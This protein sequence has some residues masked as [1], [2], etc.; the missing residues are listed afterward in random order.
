M[1][2]MELDVAQQ[3]STVGAAKLELLT[4]VMT[5]ARCIMSYDLF[6]DKSGNHR[7]GRL[8][9]LGRSWRLPSQQPSIKFAKVRDTVGGIVGFCLLY[10]ASCTAQSFLS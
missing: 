1:M 5:D 4:Y 10:F 3:A 7:E 8:H 9:L 6:E 2:F